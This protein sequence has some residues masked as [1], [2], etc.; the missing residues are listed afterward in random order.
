MN[1]TVGGCFEIFLN[2]ESVCKFHNHV[3]DYGLNT[4]AT[5]S[6]ENLMSR[7]HVGSGS[8]NPADS[9]TT[10]VTQVAYTTNYTTN[11][12]IYKA[13]S[14]VAKR[15]LFTFASGVAEGTLT[16]VGVSDG[17]S[18]FNRQL[19]KDYL[20][21]NTTVVVGASDILD[22]LCE[23][24]VYMP[25]AHNIKVTNTD[26]TIGSISYPSNYSITNR[27]YDYSGIQ[28]SG[29]LFPRQ[30]LN[31]F[32]NKIY[33]GILH[34]TADYSSTDSG[35]NLSGLDDYSP[36]VVTLQSYVTDSFTLIYEIEWTAGTLPTNNYDII[37]LSIPYSTYRKL[38]ELGISPGYNIYAETTW[39]VSTA[40]TL[41]DKFT[42]ADGNFIYEVI[43]AGTSHTAAPTWPTTIGGTVTDGNGVEYEC[44]AP[45]LKVTSTQTLKLKVALSWGRET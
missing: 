13:D 36:N 40:Y 17:T 2:G 4:M 8:T 21:N 41:G 29:L 7:C 43:T 37:T 39:A 27:F 33:W 9:D 16:E 20:G 1:F 15:R 11:T 14:Y 38:F 32:T 28:A 30:A 34:T 18:L 31:V 6:I 3:T 26:F 22:V 12:E 45:L 5:K 19:F 24:R 10:L 23:I 42:S 35:K 25:Q 44:V